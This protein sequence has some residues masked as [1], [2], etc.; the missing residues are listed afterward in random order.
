MFQINFHVAVVKHTSVFVH[1]ENVHT[2]GL[3]M[4]SLERKY[5]NWNRM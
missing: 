3:F 5:Q 4:V 2:L 1:E